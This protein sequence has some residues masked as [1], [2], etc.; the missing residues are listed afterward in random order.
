L[1]GRIVVVSVEEVEGVEV[2]FGCSG[3]DGII[4][5]VVVNLLSEWL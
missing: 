3:D 1:V 5:V 2:E 4:V